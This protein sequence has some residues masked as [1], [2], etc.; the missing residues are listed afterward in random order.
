VAR[1]FSAKT[2]INSSIDDVFDFVADYR[3]VPSVLD[4]VKRWEPITSH[5]KG[6]GATY[7]VEMSALGI[8]MADTLKL[9]LWERPHAIGW[10]S[11]GGI[12]P[13]LGRWRFTARDG[14]VDVELRIRYAPP[15]GIIGD[16]LARPLDGTVR[17]RLERAVAR[18]KQ[19]I[20]TNA[21][22]PRNRPISRGTPDK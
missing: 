1:E 18:M 20:E 9:D 22:P 4:G 3:N 19:A 2:F 11:V 16:A 5:S 13:Q 21:S 17:R 7:R 8:P 10:H 6:V 14:G 15:A 12:M